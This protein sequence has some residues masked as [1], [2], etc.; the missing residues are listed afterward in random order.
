M[1]LCFILM[2]VKAGSVEIVIKALNQIPEVKEAY[3]VTGEIDIIAKVEV[4]D[5][6]SIAKVVLSKIHQTEGVDRTSTHIVVPL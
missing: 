4:K 1:T 3:T 2:K 5:L 6:E